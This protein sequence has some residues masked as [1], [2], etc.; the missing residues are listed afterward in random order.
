MVRTRGAGEHT[1]DYI[2]QAPLTRPGLPSHVCACPA[3]G[4]GVLDQGG[5]TPP[6]FRRT[7]AMLLHADRAT[8]GSRTSASV[9]PALR[10]AAAN[11]LSP[12]GWAA[13]RSS[14]AHLRP[15]SAVPRSGGGAEAR[16]LVPAPAVGARERAPRR[17]RRRSCDVLH[18]Y[19]LRDVLH[20]AELAKEVTTVSS[21]PFHASGSLT[22]APLQRSTFAAAA[23][24]GTRIVSVTSAAPAG[25]G[26]APGPGPRGPRALAP[27][28][29]VGH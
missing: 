26:A 4:S 9:M 7:V 11:A 1:S 8:A 2:M 25:P 17:R 22:T 10:A 5:R 29:S 28:D 16:S 19:R 6:A 21:G 13:Q 24:S 18:C 23:A 3:A 27:S 12:D 14:S 20:Q 15:V